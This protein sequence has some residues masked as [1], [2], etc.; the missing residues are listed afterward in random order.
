MGLPFYIKN[1]SNA[2]AL[3]WGYLALLKRFP[4][5]LNENLLA[6]AWWCIDCCLELWL[7]SISCWYLETLISMSAALM[8]PGPGVFKSFNVSRALTGTTHSK[9]SC[10][11][12]SFVPWYKDPQ[13]QMSND[14]PIFSQGFRKSCSRS[15]AIFEK[16]L[17]LLMAADAGHKSKFV[18]LDLCRFLLTM[19]SSW[20]VLC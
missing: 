16:L 1:A 3:I 8:T 2:P 11:R 19:R 4:S 12:S 14:A 20:T 9:R 10:F 13:C 15:N 17:D 18:L 5:W 7:R 6:W